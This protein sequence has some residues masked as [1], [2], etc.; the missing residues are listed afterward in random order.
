[1]D[2]WS[3]KRAWREAQL[4]S[5][6]SSRAE[7][8][9]KRTSRITEHRILQVRFS[10]DSVAKL[11]LRRLAIRDSI[12]FMDRRRERRLMGR[13]ENGQGQFFYSFDLPCG[14]NSDPAN[15]RSAVPDDQLGPP[16]PVGLRSAGS[17]RLH[18]VENTAGMEL[19]VFSW[20]DYRGTAPG[21]DLKGTVQWIVGGLHIPDAVA[22]R[23]CVDLLGRQRRARTRR[24][25]RSVRHL[26]R[27]A[28]AQ[29]G[30]QLLSWLTS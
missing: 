30:R 25:R 7:L 23:P 1:M 5:V 18:G 3:Q 11:S 12:G 19:L 20:P 9:K 10:A 27:R 26:S 21:T 2:T 6:L 24:Y 8:A 13:R 28:L 29:S 4:R 17:T 14:P 22:A 15:R 16:H